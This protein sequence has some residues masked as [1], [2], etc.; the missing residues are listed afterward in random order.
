M[1]ILGRELGSEI[2]AVPIFCALGVMSSLL[3]SICLAAENTP[4]QGVQDAPGAGAVQ[5][6]STTLLRGSELPRVVHT[7]HENVVRFKTDF[8][9]KPFFDILPFLNA[10]TGEK[11][12]YKITFGTGSGQSG[13]DC[14]I[15]SPAEIA[16]IANW[17]ASDEIHVAGLVKDVMMATVI[18]DPCALSK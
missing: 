4:S 16:E 7:Y 9:G 1:R 6:I 8:L 18:L 2:S 12:S 14:T 3:A 13:V 15:T 17:K 5:S 11:G 10:K